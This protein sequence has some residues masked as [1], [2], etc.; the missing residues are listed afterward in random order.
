MLAVRLLAAA[1][2]ARAADDEAT[3]RARSHYEMG[4][5]LFDVRNHDQAL[6]E[7]QTANELKSRPAALFMMAQCEYLLGRLK[8][9]RAH[10][11]RYVAESPEGEFIELAKDRIES[12]NKR[13]STFVINTV[14]DDVTVHIAP[15]G[16]PGDT[17]GATIDG[18]AP[19]NF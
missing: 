18:Q 11:E 8:D 12:I 1:P 13:P 2:Q 9:A 6:I 10:Y 5:R 16:P 17:P 15:E 19:N 4:L 7:F 3:T 14:P